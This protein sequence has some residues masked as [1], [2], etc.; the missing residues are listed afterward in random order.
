V[1]LRDAALFLSRG[2]TQTRLEGY[3]AT[4]LALCAPAAVAATMSA[5]SVNK[6]FLIVFVSS[7]RE[8][9]F[10]THRGY[11]GR[12]TLT[13]GLHPK[14]RGNV[15]ELSARNP[16]PSLRESLIGRRAG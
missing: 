1:K 5:E 4:A 2:A 13:V 8:M 9:Q 14:F 16:H 6:V 7:V 12:G 10:R 11:E 15:A 3:D